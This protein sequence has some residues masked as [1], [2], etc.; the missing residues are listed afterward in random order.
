M[1]TPNT[2]QYISKLEGREGFQ[3]KYKTTC[4]ISNLSIP[5]ESQ[6]TSCKY[7]RF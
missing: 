3:K 7:I 5:K 2:A 1:A 4:L 6:S